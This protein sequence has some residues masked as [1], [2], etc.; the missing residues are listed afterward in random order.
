MFGSGNDNDGLRAIVIVTCGM[1]AGEVPLAQAPSPILLEQRQ[2][3]VALVRHLRQHVADPADGLALAA[4]RR[5]LQRLRAGTPQVATVPVAPSATDDELVDSLRI[6]ADLW[7]A[8][9]VDRTPFGLMPRER[10]AGL[11]HVQRALGQLQSRGGRSG[12]DVWLP[13]VQDELNA[14]VRAANG[15]REVSDA[16]ID[17]ALR[18]ACRPGPAGAPS[19]LKPWTGPRVWRPS[20]ATAPHLAPPSTRC[21]SWVLGCRPEASRR[22]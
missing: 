5:D 3:E 8:R 1:C 17:L 18:V 20:S 10:L 9:L 6:L 19:P 13:E 15:Q 12:L 16:A 11:T 22:R 14:L 7:H 4:D 21:E 2:R